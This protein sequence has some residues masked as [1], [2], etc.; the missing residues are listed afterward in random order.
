MLLKNTLLVLSLGML[1]HGAMA[2][3][4]PLTGA[5]K[6]TKIN[7]YCSDLTRV[8]FDYSHI[9]DG[10]DRTEKDNANIAFTRRCIGLQR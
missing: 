1:T 9:P 2:A 5:Q 8:K 6:D 7:K 4:K 3:T 10:P